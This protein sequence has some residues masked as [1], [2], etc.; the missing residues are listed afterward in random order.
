LCKEE[1]EH[2]AEF[3]LTHPMSRARIITE[4][5]FAVISQIIVLNLSVVAVTALGVLIID[6]DADAKKLALLFLANFIL[7]LEIALICFGIS[8]FLR[9]NGIGIGLGVAVL[10]YFMNII[11]NLTDKVEFL[12][13]FTPYGFTDGSYII[14]EGRID[15]K[16]LWVGL[17]FTVVGGI[18]AYLKYTKKDIA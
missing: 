10:F 4:K 3:L 1:K 2:T 11:A 5:L 9:G 13:Y 16:Y 7:Q 15:G 17:I 8:A 12:K 14:S 18:S 6:A